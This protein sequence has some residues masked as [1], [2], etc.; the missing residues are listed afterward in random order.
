MSGEIE[1]GKFVLKHQA[2]KTFKS[3]QLYSGVGSV[4]IGGALA[5]HY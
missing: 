3:W 2:F 4:I 5:Y 1:Y